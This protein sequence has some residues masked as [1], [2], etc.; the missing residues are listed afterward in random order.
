[1]VKLG[2]TF[3]IFVVLTLLMLLAPAVM[4]APVAS[5]AANSVVQEV[6]ATFTYSEIE[7][8]QWWPFTAGSGGIQPPGPDL[9]QF[10]RDHVIVGVNLPGCGFRNY[11]TGAGSA[12]GDLVGTMDLAWLSTNFSMKYDKPAQLYHNYGTEAH[13][14][15]MMGRG[16]YYEE[17][18]TAN[19]FTFVFALD[20]DSDPDITNAVGKGLFLS[21]EENG[22]FGDMAN[23]PEQRHKIIGAFDVLKSGAT[24]TWN[25]HLRN[26][27]PSEVFDLGIL[28][29]DG[30]VLQE[31][32]DAIHAGVDLL[33]FQAAGPQ[34]TIKN[35]TTDFEE[36]TWGRDPLKTVTGGHLGVGGEMDVS[37]NTIL[38]L[39]INLGAGWVRIQGTTGNNIYINDTDTGV[40]AGDGSKYGELYELLLLYIPDQTLPIGDFFSQFGYTFTSFEMHNASTGWYEGSENFADPAQI[41]IESAVGVSAQHSVDHSYGLYPH[42]KVESVFPSNGFPG[43][44][45][46]V[47]I[48]GKYFL[49]AAGQKSGWVANSGDVDFG[50]NITVNS[51]TIDTSNPI[52]N[53][54]TANITIAGGAG[55]GAQVVNVTSC[56]NY[57]NGTGVAP[58]Q[59]GTGVFNVVATGSTLNGTVTFTGRGSPPDA[60][61]IETFEVKGFEPGNLDFEVWSRTATTDNNGTF[62]L[63]GLLPETYDI[64]IKNLT[65]LS[66]IATNVTLSS[67]GEANFSNREGDVKCSDKVDGFDFAL[68][69]GA[70]GSRPGDGNWN[71]NADLN[72]SG[73]VDGFDFALLS[74]NYGVRGSGYG[75]FTC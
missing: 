49:R 31:Q 26:Y 73:K 6:E 39:E 27:D 15:W 35:Y 62:H 46:D 23:P 10:T 58:Y 75:Y 69:S 55:A 72:R 19:N 36:V 11:T 2:K 52:D 3:S 70:Y 22:I 25:L 13:F 30:G 47:K 37:R 53:S 20:F 7:P 43:T 66:E 5:V 56:F 50:P 18:N 40:R 60:K 34:P 16:H 4:L 54:I 64:G 24:Y 21:V 45:M 44:T 12:T 38:Y 14:G 28:T 1:V 32:T 17:G 42:P 33:D 65:C 8:G 29:V 9:E 67:P 48:S 41:D 68:L 59:Y 63:S 71:A 74:G 57:N 61:F 51:Y